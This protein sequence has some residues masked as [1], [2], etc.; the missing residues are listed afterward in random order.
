MDIFKKTKQICRLYGIEPRRSKGQNFLISEKIYDRIVKIS[1]ISK[2]DVILEVGPGLGFLTAKLAKKAKK[3]VAVELDDELSAFLKEAVDSQK[4]EN[5]EIINKNVLDIKIEDI[6]SRSLIQNS[7]FKI[8]ANL[9]YNISSVFLRKFLSENDIKP[10][11]MVLMLQKEVAERITAG[12]GDMSLLA[13]SVRLYADAKIVSKVPAKAFWPRPEVDSAI[14]KIEKQKEKIKKINEKDLFR[15]LKFGFAAKRKMLRNN[16]AAGYRIKPEEVDA[17]I[18]ESGLKGTSRA[19][20]L[21][22][23]DWLLLYECIRRKRR[24]ILDK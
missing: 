4:V 20:D 15:L 23:D 16:L 24:S 22:I 14:V 18:S 17:I 21:S 9:P 1:D 5:V 10:D 3:V 8:V 2:K 13:C 19:Q 11:S 7:G 12:P 6:F